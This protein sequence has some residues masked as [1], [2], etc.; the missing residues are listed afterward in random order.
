MQ[1]LDKK[2][3]QTLN[4]TSQLLLLTM[5]THNPQQKCPLWAVYKSERLR[6][7][8]GGH[9][10]IP[11]PQ[12][13]ARPYLDGR[14]NL[15][16]SQI[17]SGESSLLLFQLGSSLDN[18]ILL[19]LLFLRLTRRRRR[20]EAF[21][22]RINHLGEPVV[23]EPIEDDIRDD[24]RHNQPGGHTAGGVFGELG[25]LCLSPRTGFIDTDGPIADLEN[26]RSDVDWVK[27]GGF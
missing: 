23:V 16:A 8:C 24:V 7:G 9:V 10:R 20:T 18:H 15:L 1:P 26:V 13:F 5:T 11:L 6:A 17:A 2:S 21:D 3:Q 12:L 22:D 27:R 14:S 4:S 25:D 19:E